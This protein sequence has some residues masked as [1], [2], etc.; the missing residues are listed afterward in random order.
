METKCC[1]VARIDGDYALLKRTDAELDT[2][3]K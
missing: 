1:I 3:L 2:M